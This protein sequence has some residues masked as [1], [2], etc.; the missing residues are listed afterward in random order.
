MPKTHPLLSYCFCLLIVSCFNLEVSLSV[1]ANWADAR[2]LFSDYNV[3]AVRAL[4][5]AVSV[6][7]EYHLVL[8]VFQKL[9]VALF[10]M[11]SISATPSNLAA[12]SSNPSSRASFAIRAYIS[13]HSKFSPAAASARLASVP[14]IL[15][16]FRY[17]YHNFAC[18]CS[19]LQSPRIWRQSVHIRLFLL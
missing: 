9:A 12:I 8:N 19:F 3:S 16:P 13:V 7:R 5:D 6:L 2:S 4:P 18:S 15:F 17:L 1:V 11:F 14:L 10:V